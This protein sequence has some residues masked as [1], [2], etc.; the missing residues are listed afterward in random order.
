MG[1]L[2]IVVLFGGC[3]SEHEVSLQSAASVMDHLPRDFYHVIPIGI[4]KQGRWLSYSG[5][6]EQIADG[7]WE[8][9]PTCCEAVLSPDRRH[10]G[11]LK[12]SPDG[13]YLALKVDCVIPVLHGK[14][15]EDGSIQGLLEIAG[16]PYVGS[17]V[18]SSAVCMDKVMTR[19]V[20]D[21]A[22]IRG[23]KWRA[24]SKDQLPRLRERADEI[25]E[26]LGFPIFVKP[27]NAGSSVG[28]TKA[29]DAESMREA[30]LLALRHDQK[31]ICEQTICGKEVECAVMGNQNPQASVLGQIISCNEFYDYDAKYQSESQLLIPADLD[32]SVAREVQR[33][34]VLAYQTLE[35]RGLARMDFLIDR[36]NQVYLNEPNTMPGFTKISMYP[37]LWKK[38]GLEYSALLQKLI[39]LAMDGE[40]P[41]LLSDKSPSL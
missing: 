22:G 39:Q 34:A 11:V 29:R 9:H 37:K 38:S 35:C 24:F 33:I 10:G 14:N 20:L 36:S 27:A 28:I 41:Q 23:A 21:C 8:K 2:N 7:R 18:L 12:L 15:G 3:S 31:V 16:I 32:P 4:T 6:V 13:S 26:A 25:A 17:G 30:I 1:K 5:P 40:S 19:T